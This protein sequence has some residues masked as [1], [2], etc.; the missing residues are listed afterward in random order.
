M[1]FFTATRSAQ[2]ITLFVIAVLSITLFAVPEIV[3][4]E[5]LPQSSIDCGTAP[6]GKRYAKF[7]ISPPGQESG[8]EEVCASALYSQNE[9]LLWPAL[10]LAIEKVKQQSPSKFSWYPANQP[11][12]GS[13]QYF[14][15]NS[16]WT[17][18]IAFD[19]S[20]NTLVAPL[21]I[22]QSKVCPGTGA[23]Q[24]RTV[25]TRLDMDNSGDVYVYF[26]GFSEVT[27]ISWSTSVAQPIAAP[28]GNTISF[29]LVAKIDNSTDVFKDVGIGCENCGGQSGLTISA[30]ESTPTYRKIK[31]V[32]NTKGVTT[33]NPTLTF[34]P[35]T[36]DLGEAKSFPQLKR[37]I[38][39]NFSSVSCGD[40]KESECKGHAQCFF[41]NNKCYS[42]ADTTVCSSL[43][44]QYCGKENG[45]PL[46]KWSTDLNICQ[47][48]T[49][50]A[51]SDEYSKPDGYEG[52]MPDCAWS[53]DCR[54]V[55]DLLRLA[56]NFTKFLFGFIGSV[57]F[58]MFVYGG[59]T[60][61]LSMGN[62]DKVSHGKQILTAAVVGLIIAFGA[63]VLVDF[64]LDAFQTNATF[65]EIGQ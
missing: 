54:D 12:E 15:C 29:E 18:E 41:F 23:T 44:E 5:F 1:K 59:F 11:V 35:I 7:Y 10:K 50:A 26:T 42:D 20:A 25:R 4:A 40:Y 52:F 9:I 32:W 8:G 21:A 16:V 19:E 30:V 33:T 51:I 22:K 38:S 45:S 13:V 63:Y 14:N 39:F 36:N 27:Q 47:N 48:P 58:V 6:D 28:L 56:I 57:A 60:I 2:K 64:L 37:T 24:E 55:N 62:S 49:Q 31:V 34:Y 65:R 53:G 61:I 17:N 46:C 43:P 3:R